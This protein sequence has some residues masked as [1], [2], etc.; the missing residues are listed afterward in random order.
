MQ[1]S[2]QELGHGDALVLR[3]KPRLSVL[4]RGVQALVS[5]LPG[6]H[7]DHPAFSRL[8][9]GGGPLPPPIFP[10]VGGSLLVRSPR[11]RRAPGSVASRRA[12]LAT[13]GM[14]GRRQLRP[15]VGHARR[16]GRGP[17]SLREAVR[18]RATRY[19]S[20]RAA[21]TS[22]QLKIW[23]AEPS[24]VR[25]QWGPQGRSGMMVGPRRSASTGSSPARRRWSIRAGRS[26]IPNLM[27]GASSG[28]KSARR[29]PSASA[30]IAASARDRSCLRP[31]S[32]S[33]TCAGSH[34]RPTSR[35]RSTNSSWVQPLDSRRSDTD[36]AITSFSGT[37]GTP[38]VSHGA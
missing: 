16:P 12:L 37:D 10:V 29:T 17:T 15:L 33:V 30:S 4:D 31:R 26:R 21:W 8:P 22:F 20:K 25:E 5:L 6:P 3:A 18:I 13:M 38:P 14:F 32:T 9:A 23:G 2:G 11:H 35:T 28:T 36:R 19:P 7:R 34:G 24:T 27:D 1:P